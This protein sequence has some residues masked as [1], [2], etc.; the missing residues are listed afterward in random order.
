VARVL[1]GV[2]DVGLALAGAGEQVDVVEA[3]EDV[4]PRELHRGA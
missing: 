2:G 4:A 3:E 1:A